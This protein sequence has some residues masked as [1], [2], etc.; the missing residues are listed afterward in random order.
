MEEKRNEKDHAFAA[1][2]R[3]YETSTVGANQMRAEIAPMPDCQTRGAIAVPGRKQRI[4]FARHYRTPC[5]PWAFRI[6]DSRKFTL[7]S[8]FNF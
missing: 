3:G 5:F 8:T 6:I 2:K 7:T 1:L 4:H